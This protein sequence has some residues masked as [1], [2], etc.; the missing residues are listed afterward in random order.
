[1]ADFDNDGDTDVFL[2]AA[3]GPA[4]FLF[5]NEVGAERSWL[6]VS[7]EGRAS[8]PEAHGAVVRLVTSAGTLTKVKAGGSGFLSQSDP[9]LL[10]GLGDDAAAQSLSVR[11]PS[12][13]EQTFP[14]PKAGQSIHLVEGEPE[15]TVVT[16]RRFA[17]PEPEDGTDRALRLTRLTRDRTLPSLGLRP[18]G[19]SPVPKLDAGPALVNLW[20]TWCIPC[21]T[22]MPELDRLA[23]ERG[24][25]VVGLSVDEE[26]S[27]A[28]LAAFR[29]SVGVSYPL[30]QVD[31]KRLG[32][33]FPEGRV[34]V[35]LTLVLDERGR[36]VEAFAGWTREARRRLDE[37]YPKG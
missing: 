33:L 18:V 7:L 31:P 17:L 32:A 2:R 27:P 20:A 36:V 13:R 23:R 1:F 21:R 12:G 9:R 24:V 8:G 5:R 25:R 6:R 15:W 37:L 28:E 22:E 3:H 14:G 34:Q 26:A 19:G 4:H 11:W 29:E 30:A 10:F 35:P 16:E